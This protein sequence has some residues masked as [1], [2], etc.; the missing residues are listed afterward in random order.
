MN[1]TGRA[2]ALALSLIIYGCGGGGGDGGKDVVVVPPTPTP[3]P[4]PTPPPLSP[5][6]RVYATSVA[7]GLI[8]FTTGDIDT[9]GLYL[10]LGFTARDGRY[11]PGHANAIAAHTGLGTA[12]EAVTTGD[13]ALR[14]KRTD[15]ID[16]ETGVRIFMNAPANVRMVTPVTALLV[17]PGSTAAKLKTQLG[18]TNSLFSMVNDP[19]LATYD[20]I[21][22]AASGDSARA[23]DAARMHAANLRVLAIQAALYTLATG[24]SYNFPGSYMAYGDIRPIITP[25]EAVATRCVAAS[26]AAFIFQNDRMSEIIKC[27]LRDVGATQP[28]PPV[29]LQL[30]ATKVQAIAHMIN[31]YAAAMPVRLETSTEKARWL[32]GI[33]GY[34][35]PMIGHIASNR[36]DNAAQAALAI[37]SPTIIAETSRYAE[38]LRYNDTGLYM[39]SPDFLILNGITTLDFQADAITENDVIFSNERF[40]TRGIDRASGVIQLVSVPQANADQISV[41]MRSPDNYTVRALNGFTGAS[42]FDYIAKAS[43]NE[44]RRTRVYVRVM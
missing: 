12:P 35:R 43:N 19:D 27:Y 36:T 18:I 2:A 41:T 13:Y 9:F 39:P 42:Y 16:H 15:V 20:A 1:K 5:T 44:E 6:A 31:A 23:A 10:T 4:T 37:R 26:S 29:S 38:F 11:Y 14:F 32:L 3:T 40:N 17:A 30:S 8:E 34:L 25:T 28:S 7:T 24:Q 33:N 22:E 21:E